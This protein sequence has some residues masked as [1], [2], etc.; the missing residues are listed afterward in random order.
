MC[1]LLN[2]FSLNLYCVLISGNLKVNP[3]D[4]RLQSN[5]KAPKDLKPC[6]VDAY[7]ILQVS[8]YQTSFGSSL[9]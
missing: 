7:L 9:D 6:A 4:V 2:I 5:N 3:A 1:C 8:C